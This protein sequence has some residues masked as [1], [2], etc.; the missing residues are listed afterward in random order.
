MGVLRLNLN[1]DYN[2]LH[3]MV[4]NHKTIRAM[5][6]HGLY[7]AGGEY[8][9]QTLKD[10]VALLTPESLDVISAIVVESG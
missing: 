1:C 5:L 3:E 9:L 6:G 4:N 8:H 2:C 7:D 10:N